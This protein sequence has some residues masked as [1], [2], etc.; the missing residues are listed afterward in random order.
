MTSFSTIPDID[1]QLFLS[2][3]GQKIPADKNLAYTNAYNLLSKVKYAPKT[4]VDWFYKLFYFDDF[5]PV[6]DHKKYEEYKNIIQSEK[7]VIDNAVVLTQECIEKD[8]DIIWIDLDLGPENDIY[9]KVIANSS[10]IPDLLLAYK[11][12]NLSFRVKNSTI[13][14]YFD[15]VTSGYN[16]EELIPGYKVKNDIKYDWTCIV[17]K[18]SDYY[19][20]SVWYFTNNDFPDL[21]AIFGIKSSLTNIL[22]KSKHRK[23]IV[24]KILEH[25]KELGKKS[26]KKKLIVPWPLPPMIHIL[27]KLK[28]KEYNTNE[29]T[30]ERQFTSPIGAS[31]SQYFIYDL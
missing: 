26:N 12:G 4:I 13:D 29:M 6:L 21:C 24:Y 1:I 17:L 28:W 2:A 8:D 19:Y 18:F 22:S 9:D 16:D 27:R 10:I 14:Y 25:A 30:Y 23:G 5:N 31:G 15:A 20:G 3:Y 11:E 7:L